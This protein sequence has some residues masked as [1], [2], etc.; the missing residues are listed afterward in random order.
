MTSRIALLRRRLL[1]IAPEETTCA[2]RRFQVRDHGARQRIEQI[3]ETFVYG[4]HA[5]LDDS[6]PA[7]LA[8][9]LGEVAAERRGFAYEGAAMALALLD[10]LTPWNR[11]RLPAFVAGFGAQHIYMVYVGVGWAFARLGWRAERMQARLDPHLSWLAID[12]YGFHQGYFGWPRYIERQARPPRLSGYALRAFDQGLGRSLWFVKGAD[13]PQ[14]AA[15]IAAFAPA[16][17]AD[18]WSGV[19]LAC[20]YAGGV[21]RGVVGHLRTLAGE[22]LPHVAQGAA[23][24]ALARWRARNPAPHTDLACQVLGG[25]SAS[26]AAALTDQVL[27]TRPDGGA[28]PMYE[29]WRGQIRAAFVAEEALAV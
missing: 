3:G 23:F 14:I 13:A 18:L 26:A 7:A 17:R 22:H 20:A 12:G 16:R 27:N 15:T 6:A 11:Y 28:V 21:E 8:A 29:V 19:G 2:R 25:M 9:R 4:Y 10:T 24:A 1:G 5:A